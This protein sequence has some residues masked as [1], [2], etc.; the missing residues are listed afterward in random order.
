MTDEKIM[1]PASSILAATIGVT[2]VGPK[3]LPQKTFPGFLRVNRTR[4]HMALEWLKKN[5]PLYKDIAISS[6]RL[7][8]LHTDSVPSEISSLARCSEDT[9]L[10]AEENDSYVPEEV[11]E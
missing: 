4:V 11:W 5:N 10:L 2:F 6:D 9:A 8:D 1:P 3:N 7:R